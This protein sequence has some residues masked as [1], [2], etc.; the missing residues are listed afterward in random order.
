MELHIGGVQKGTAHS[1]KPELTN[2]ETDSRQV[3]TNMFCPLNRGIDLETKVQVACFKRA[4]EQPFTAARRIVEEVV[5]ELVPIETQTEQFDPEYLARQANRRRQNGRP[6][7]PKNLGSTSTDWF[8]WI[9][10]I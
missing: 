9:K 6:H 3:E 7:H 8:R 5:L 1:A 4:R 10:S 2:T